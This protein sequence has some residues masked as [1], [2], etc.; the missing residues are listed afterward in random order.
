M[1]IFGKLL[2]NA[3]FN[4]PSLSLDDPRWG[5]LEGGYR[6]VEYNASIDLKS[7][8]RAEST[9]QVERIY[10][11]L[12]NDLH[13]QGDVGLASYYAVPHLVRIAQQNGIINNDLLGLVS[14][15]EIQRHNNNP[16][17]PK[18]LISDY[19]AAIKSLG[20]L[21]IQTLIN[22]WDLETTAVTLAAIAVS[23]QQITIAEAILNLDDENTID[24]LIGD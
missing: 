16:A 9:E 14:V 19:T 10:A 13:H 4:E 15:I 1:G 20:T 22:P 2:G 8:E 12:W 21:A 18:A 5:S 24:E 23:K 3:L 7:L 17:L 6:N 11:G